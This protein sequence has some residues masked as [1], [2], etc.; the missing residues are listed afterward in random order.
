MYQV[1]GVG[2][3]GFVGYSG[4]KTWKLRQEDGVEEECSWKLE[5]ADL[6]K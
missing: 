4:T 5:N 1:L 6:T 2:W 3:K